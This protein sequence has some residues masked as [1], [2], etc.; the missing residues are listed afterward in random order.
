MLIYLAIMLAVVVLVGASCNV[1]SAGVGTGVLPAFPG[2]D[3]F[4]LVKNYVGDLI[5]WLAVLAIVCIILL[6]LRERSLRERLRRV[7]PRRQPIADPR[8]CAILIAYN[9]EESIGPVISD[10]RSQPYVERV[11]VVDNNCSDQTAAR[12][13]AAGASVVQEPNQGYGYACIRGLRAALEVT[14]ASVVLL[15]EGDGTFS[16][17]DI[18]KMIP[19]LEEADFVVGNRVTPGLVD[20]RSQMDSFFVWGNQLGAKLLQLRFWDWR[21][22]GQVRLGD[23]GCTMR[24][25]RRE[26]LEEIID[27][28]VVGG[29]HFSPHMLMTAIRHGQTVVEIPITFWPRVGVSKGASRNLVRATGVGLAMLWH[30]MTYRPNG[31]RKRAETTANEKVA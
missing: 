6:V 23:L 5:L 24:A 10:F 18:G 22:L 26:A 31:R 1:I 11:I 13:L 14:D 3:W 12:A 19:F 21:F 4:F 28:L 30:I 25:L 20:T 15:A 27:D 17:H 16:G 7:Q 8:I 29:D 9:E 2:S